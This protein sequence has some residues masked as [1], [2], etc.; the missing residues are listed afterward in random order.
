MDKNICISEICLKSDNINT[1][2]EILENINDELENKTICSEDREIILKSINQFN[3][4][5]NALSNENKSLSDKC[6][7][8]QKTL[9]QEEKQERIA[10]R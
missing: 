5:I 9:L 2:L 1:L 10:T 7:I 3:A 4:I 8:L 6:G